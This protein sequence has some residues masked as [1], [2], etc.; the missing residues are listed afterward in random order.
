MKFKRRPKFKKKKKEKKP[1]LD[2]DG[3]PIKKLE[4]G[5]EGALKMQIA[6]KIASG[7]ENIDEFG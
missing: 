7:N 4:W 1:R 6:L 3:K 2:L 5:S